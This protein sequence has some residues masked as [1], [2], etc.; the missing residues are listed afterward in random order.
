MIS[1]SREF[2]FFAILM[3]LKKFFCITKKNLNNFKRQIIRKQNTCAI[4]KNYCILFKCNL[5]IYFIE[6]K[7][8]NKSSSSSSIS[9]SNVL[10]K[11][12]FIFIFCNRLK[13]FN[14]HG[15]LKFFINL[16]SVGTICVCLFFL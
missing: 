1:I 13:S 8:N 6:K 7:N 4:N 14:A 10:K 5:W 12:N 9:I 11:R 16:S 3:T 15:Y 2:I